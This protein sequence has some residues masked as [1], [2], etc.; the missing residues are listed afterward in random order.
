MCA[1]FYECKLNYYY[2]KNCIW[3]SAIA[4]LSLNLK[5]SVLWKSGTVVQF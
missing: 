5:D 1:T 3:M 2:K 4:Y